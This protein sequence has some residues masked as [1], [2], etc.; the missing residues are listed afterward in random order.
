MVKAL[1]R[2]GH[3]VAMTGDG[4]NDV[5]ALK[6]AD[7]GVAM[8]SGSE[9]ACPVAHVV[10]M[11]SDFASMPSVVMEGRRVINN[12]ERSAS[13]FLV[14]NIFSFVMAIIS[15]F[16]TL[17]YPLTPSQLSL[18]SSMTIG[19]PGFV[20]AME[21]N[22]S[23]VK[24]KFLRNIMLRALPGGITNIVLIVGVM[25]FYISFSLPDEQMST[26]CAIIMAV[27]GIVVLHHNCQPYNS[28]RKALMGTVVAVILICVLFLKQL[29][30]LSDLSGS[31]KL[32]LGVFA[33]MAYPLM[34]ALYKYTAILDKHLVERDAAR[35]AERYRG[36]QKTKRHV[37]RK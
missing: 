16:F 23:I 14:K 3:T 28:I 5:L 29:F 30:T 9:V 31:S 33:V 36:I 8:A 7:C 6:E 1:K 26:I 12:I 11:N 35:K 22:N 34:T 27:V 10:L 2:H 20:L 32:V 21:P 24:G 25:M 15:L 13:L 37:G 19:F 17:P 18:V 4:V